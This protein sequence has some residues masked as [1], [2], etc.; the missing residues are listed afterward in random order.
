VQVFTRYMQLIYEKHNEI[1]RAILAKVP[2]SKID[3]L[4]QD[5]SELEH[6]CAACGR[7]QAPVKSGI[8]VV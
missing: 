1:D 2:E 3:K 5:I 4:R 8:N 6:V 7:T